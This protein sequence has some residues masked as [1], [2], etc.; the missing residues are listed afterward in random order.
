[1]ILA[2]AILAEAALATIGFGQ[3][4]VSEQDLLDGMALRVLSTEY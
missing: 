3:I 4:T 2:G 1:V